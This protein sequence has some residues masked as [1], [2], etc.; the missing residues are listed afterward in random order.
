MKKSVTITSIAV[1][2]AAC[3]V[4]GQAYAADLGGYKDAP[5]YAAYGAPSW[6]GFYAGVNAGAVDNNGRT[7][8]SYS[9]A[10]G[11]GTGNFSDFFGSSADNAAVDG[12][13]AGLM[14]IDGLNAAQS[15]V[16]EGIIPLALGSSDSIGFA[17]G[18]QIGYNL[19]RGAFV[20]G[21]ETDLSWF[22]QSSSASFSTTIPYAFTN[23][24]TD[25][26]SVEWLGTA[27]LRAGYAFDRLLPYVTGGLAYGGAKASSTSVGS[28][29]YHTDTF[30]GSTSGT[31]TGYVVGGGLDYWLSNRW[32]FRFE[33]FYYNLGTASYN[34]APQDANSISEGLS[35]T[36]SHT[37]D[38]AVVRAGLNHAF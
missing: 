30:S 20:I 5:G 9:Y 14:N 10:P 19:Q 12:Q 13:P 8:H 18:G 32:S 22:N 29:G 36:A 27:R 16:A 28:D 4:T 15:A 2:L 31:R 25:K 33:G 24:G 6:A 1:A 37:F 26:S 21:A 7:T 35:V 11:N 38:G 17:G 23:A 34:V 3:A